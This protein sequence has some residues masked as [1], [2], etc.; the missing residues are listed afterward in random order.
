MERTQ[1]G[2]DFGNNNSRQISTQQMYM[3]HLLPSS[4]ILRRLL[5]P[6]VWATIEGLPFTKEGN[7][8]AKH[9]LKTKYG[10][11]SEIMS[12]HVTNIMS[13]PVIYGSN[14]KKDFGIL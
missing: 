14:P 2:H 1:I 11:E 3:C 12:T 5:E 6:K 4:R 9:I 8:R 13:L 7:E 10:K